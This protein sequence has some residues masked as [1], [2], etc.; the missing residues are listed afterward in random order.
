MARIPPAL[1]HR[2]FRIYWT[3]SVLSAVGSEFTMVAMA[4]QVYDLTSSPL[5]VGLLGLGRA[6]PQMAL[7]M[8]GGLLAD[9]V[10]RKRL[11]LALQ[12]AQ[13]A[14][15]TSLALLTATGT[16]SSGALFFAA[17]LL[18]FCTALETP[19]RTAVVPN[20]LPRE[21]LA[22]AVGLSTTQRSIAM[23]AGPSLAGIILA[24]AGPTPCYVV[25]ATSWFA[26]L[27]ALLT[28]R[29]PLQIAAPGAIS[30]QALSA[31][32]K[33]VVSR[34]VIF[35]FMILNFG[36]TFF[37]STV[38]L[39]PIYARD[40]LHVG[41]VELGLL[42][43]ANS[44]GAIIAGTLLSTRGQ[45]DEAGKWVL[46]GTSIYATCTIGFGLSHSF[47]LSLLLLALSGAGGTV[48]AILRGVA[49]QILTPDEFRGRVAS[50][51]SVFVMGGPQLGQFESGAIASLFNTR[52]STVS[53][54]LGALAL[55]AGIALLSRVRS[56]RFSDV[57]TKESA[58]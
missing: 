1:R 58:F 6:L 3:G 15:S 54:G 52:F 28:I 42:Y 51:N 45:V 37:G 13:C 34:Q 23:I 30:I 16:I 50:V 43:A 21:D 29:Q 2:D 26:M 47:E 5:Q 18:A 55:T 46:I 56:F 36:A 25:D 31:G 48:S 11:M 4:W 24:V 7:S 40:I 44:V 49:N 22:S 32:I 57:A 14:I 12:F 9:A 33:F 17:V 10:D 38:A 20:L 35:A 39:L 41:Q 19:S 53:G 8:Y 27:G